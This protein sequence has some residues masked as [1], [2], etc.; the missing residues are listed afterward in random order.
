MRRASLAFG[1]S[2]LGLLVAVAVEAC[3]SSSAG[4][5]NGPIAS[6]GG[7]SGVGTMDATT[8]DAPNEGGMGGAPTTEYDA[9]CGVP[10]AGGC[11]PDDVNACLFTTGGQS[12]RGA[13]GASSGSAGVAG[14]G[15]AG[16]ASGFAG[17]TSSA[18]EAGGG[19]QGGEAGIGQAGSTP[20]GSS[21]SSGSAGSGAGTSGSA[22]MDAGLPRYSCQV[23]VRRAA[24]QASCVLSGPGGVDAP[25]LSGS[26][27]QPSLACVGKVAG[28]CRPYCC[29]HSACGTVQGTHCAEEALL[30]VPE[31]DG[32]APTAPVCVPA[33]ECSLAE[34]FP[35]TGSGC[36]CPDETACMVVSDEGKTS[37]V[38]PGDGATGEAC[39][40]RWGHV[41]SKAT[42]ECVKLCQTAAPGDDCGSGRC[43]AA[44]VLPPG[45]GVCVGYV[46]QEAR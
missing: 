28:R 46:P 8:V 17:E 13:G 3:G 22:G 26:D 9:L 31:I 10:L 35:C 11:V 7:S 42:N 14:S 18:G 24:P 5:P 16:N 34:D 1:Y 37:C 27:C 12:G 20:Q 19:G 15:G 39:P 25:C 21:G 41:C 33:A 29:D 30:G 2:L 38:V 44:P 4:P 32:E 36:T 43:Q 45:W 23:G 6:T 40:C